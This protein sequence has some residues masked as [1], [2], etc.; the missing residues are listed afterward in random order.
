MLRRWMTTFY[1]ADLHMTTCT[2]RLR[3]I[4]AQDC[5]YHKHLEII[6]RKK[7]THDASFAIELRVAEKGSG[8]VM[9][10]MQEL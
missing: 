9:E 6:E 7:T 3:T 10:D 5:T 4:T 2:A 8:G 1:W